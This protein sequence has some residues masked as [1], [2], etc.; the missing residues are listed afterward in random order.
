MMVLHRMFLFT[1]MLLLTQ[2][3][4]THMHTHRCIHMPPCRKYYQINSLKIYPVIDYQKIC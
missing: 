2:V 1:M 3:F 4:L